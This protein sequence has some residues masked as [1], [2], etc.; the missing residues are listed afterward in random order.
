[1]PGPAANSRWSS[2]P[3]FSLGPQST[4][5]CVLILEKHFSLSGCFWVKN[6]FRGIQ[7]KLYFGELDGWGL[8]LQSVSPVV[9]V[10]R[11]KFL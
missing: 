2:L 3:Q 6:P 8:P 10:Q 7:I 11:S 9:P 1:M 5:L 4:S